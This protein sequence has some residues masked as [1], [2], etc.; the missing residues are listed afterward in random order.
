MISIKSPVLNSHNQTIEHS[1]N[2]LTTKVPTA[3]L[4]PRQLVYRG[5]VQARGLWFDLDVLDEATARER[6]LDCW[7]TGAT[8]SRFPDGLLSLWPH[9]RRVVC[10]RVLALPLVESEGILL[11]A[12]LSPAERRQLLGEEPRAAL[13]TLVLVRASQAQVR[14]VSDA[15]S[16]DIAR[17]L[18]VSNFRVEAVQS[19]G[20]AP[21]APLMLVQPTDFDA[22]QALTGQEADPQLQRV[23][24]ALRGENSAIK[25][26]KSDSVLQ[27][28]QGLGASLLNMVDGVRSWQKPRLGSRRP[29]SLLTLWLLVALAV[30][31]FRG[32]IW[33][34]LLAM[35]A[36]WLLREIL[37]PIQLPGSATRVST[38]PSSANVA[39]GS[40]ILSAL[41]TAL[42]RLVARFP[43]ANRKKP[44][45]PNAAKEPL[46]F[47]PKVKPKSR[48]NMNDMMRRALA[49]ALM[50]SNLSR[51]IGR[52]QARYMAQMMEMFERGDWDKALRHA[53]P[54]GALPGIGDKNWNPPPFLGR[55]FARNDLKIQPRVQTAGS[56]VGLGEELSTRL[57]ALYRR[58]FENL[59][60]RE[61][62]E[63]AAFVLA[64]LLGDNEEAVAFLE[65][66]DRKVLAAEMAEARNLPAGLIVR[67]WFLAGDEARAIAVA[68][69]HN[70]FADAVLRLEQ[71][72]D[73]RAE[74]LRVLW[75]RTLGQSGQYAAAVEVLWPIESLREACRA[76][77]ELALESGGESA[78]RVLARLLQLDKNAFQDESL[79]HR[80]LDLL[81]DEEQEN[82]RARLAFAQVLRGY[83]VALLHNNAIRNAARLAARALLRDAANGFS[84]V[85]PKAFNGLLDLSRDGALRAD[86]PALPSN[87]K[88]QILST[89]TTPL[90]ISMA[91]NDTGTTPILD[92][93]FLPDGKCVVALG[94][95]GAQLLNREGRIVHRFDQPCHKLVLSDNGDRAIALAP[96]GQIQSGVDANGQAEIGTVY[97]LAHLDFARRTAKHWCEA[98]VG[99]H[100]D[101]H[102][103]S[104]WYAS[105]GRELCAIDVLNPQFAALWKSGDTGGQVII[106]S[107]Q[108]DSCSLMTRKQE[109]IGAWGQRLAEPRVSL[110][111][112]SFTLSG[113]PTLRHRSAPVFPADDL[114]QPHLNLL[115]LQV[116][117]IASFKPEAVETDAAK[118]VAQSTP[119]P[120][121]AEPLARPIM[122]FYTGSGRTEMV[123]PIAQNA[124]PKT[125]PSLPRDF[126]LL[127]SKEMRSPFTPVFGNNWYAAAMRDE[128]GIV[129]FLLDSAKRQVR[130]RVCLDG[131]TDVSMRFAPNY[132]VLCDNLGRLLVIDLENGQLV[133]DL[134]L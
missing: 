81:E 80:V 42:A 113:G 73:E 46:G 88:S 115:P 40:V 53:I 99:A 61:R 37:P 74:W 120:R 57:R 35:F 125:S 34:I 51:F 130:A 30:A 41:A 2:A 15:K 127:A 62:W 119:T 133:R 111:I 50:W 18:D 78:S 19:L 5:V 100:V 39:S 101:S 124:T 117:L 21:A 14:A 54:M 25:S 49:Q 70:A 122:L 38:A 71:K 98:I 48:D 126:V 72:Q 96:R 9:A 75:A 22:R 7:T 56:S 105:V 112:W 116:L 102:D 89:R 24:D 103:G 45:P 84:V 85:E 92:A 134:R 17:W 132:L 76:Y 82:A 52:H 67:Q 3:P 16:E 11:S 121:A 66:H 13:S 131:A 129:C 27:M 110:E 31:V 6:V 4:R 104:V 109:A 43:F 10:E 123:P 83:N 87:T 64:E 47:K 68:R 33:K 97:R 8:V 128:S 86:V 29:L 69:R 94:E 55:L 60:E 1:T 44:K 28:L 26:S 36:V 93:A 118:A 91:A 58:A 23:L 106:A 114:V 65:A 108:G 32:D 59:K 90:D 63:E 77:A 95:A 79:R 20:E 107:R 12:P